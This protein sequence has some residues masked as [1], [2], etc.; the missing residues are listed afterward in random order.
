MERPGLSLA[1]KAEARG[2]SCEHKVGGA[3][4]LQMGLLPD[5]LEV[6]RA[7]LT[8]EFPKV[9]QPQWTTFRLV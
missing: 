5:L 8:L 7:A 1:L 3:R 9:V 2:G 4:K 6:K